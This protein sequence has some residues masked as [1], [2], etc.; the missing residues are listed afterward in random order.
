MAVYC[1]SGSAQ[2]L[3]RVFVATFTSK[4]PTQLPTL[5]HRPFTAPTSIRQ[6][7]RAYA[8]YRGRTSA[9][10]VRRERWNE[11]IIGDSV[12]LVDSKTER[13][14]PP[15]SKQGVLIRLDLKTHRLVEVA[16]TESDGSDSIAICKIVEK[17]AASDAD[18]AR[19]AANKQR[20]KVR[21]LE[22]TVKT[23]EL[24]WAIDSN[25]LGHRLDKVKMFLQEGRRVDIVLAP[26]KRGRKALLPECQEVISRI[27]SSLKSINGAEEIKEM[28]GKIGGVAMF[29]YQGKADASPNT[30]K[31]A[32]S[33]HG[34]I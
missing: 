31:A 11:D 34:E 19:K 9:P 22:T 24:N 23:I 10:E 33:S 13:L 12:V 30:T 5:R 29:S 14:Q 3:Y 25:D 26:K 1:S 4:R 15:V 8:I 7:G 32:E 21:A 2:A 28:E 16:R 6:Q 17:K 18:R 20:A 27:R